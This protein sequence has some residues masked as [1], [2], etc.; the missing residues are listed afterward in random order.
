MLEF[1]AGGVVI[2]AICA[3]PHVNQIV[4]AAHTESEQEALRFLKTGAKGAPDWTYYFK[5]VVEESDSEVPEEARRFAT[6]TC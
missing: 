3:A 2:N 4:L 6:K 1:D 5:Y